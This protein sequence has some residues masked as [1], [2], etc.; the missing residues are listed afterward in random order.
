MYLV[1]F[2]E[3]ERDNA[4]DD[5]VSKRSIVGRQK[6]LDVVRRDSA[7]VFRAWRRLIDIPLDGDVRFVTWLDGH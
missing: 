4:S 2:H 7:L 6:L 3:S 1:F 5:V